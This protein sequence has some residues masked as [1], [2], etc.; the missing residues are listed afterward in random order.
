MRVLLF[1][2]CLSIMACTNTANEAM[3]QAQ[4][5]TLTKSLH[6]ASAK[7]A[8]LEHQIEPEGD[9]VHLVFFKV[10]SD[11]DQAALVAAIKKLATIE[12]VMD[13]EV[14]PFEDIGDARALSDYSL[15]M[16]MSFADKAA[17]ETYQKH[18]VHLELK[19]KLGAFMAGPPATYDFMKK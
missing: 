16:Q 5:E 8:N 1:F 2:C 11:A 4:I 9:L 14:G 17:Y 10:K 13:L 18:P 15:L 7:A 6:L 12:A 3:L 19:E